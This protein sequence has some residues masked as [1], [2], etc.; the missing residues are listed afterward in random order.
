MFIF[1]R[2]IADKEKVPFA[3]YWLFL[4]GF[5]NLSTKQGL[6][7]LEDYLKVKSEKSQNLD[8]DSESPK[9]S[10]MSSEDSSQR[11]EKYPKDDIKRKLLFDDET[12]YST[13]NITD[14]E[15]DINFDDESLEHNDCFV[16]LDFKE[17]CVLFKTCMR[18]KEMNVHIS[19]NGHPISQDK[20]SS[21]AQEPF[22]L[23]SKNTVQK[24][25]VNIV[26]K[27]IFIDGFV[28]FISIF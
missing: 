24:A 12:V 9:E 26:R 22:H 14:F 2:E 8:Y 3:E 16:N 5:Y 23:S 7:K 1:C 27:L 15:N 11:N 13:D 6:Q 18:N 4:N 19:Q 25:G 10:F 21:L 20:L 28:Y 17:L